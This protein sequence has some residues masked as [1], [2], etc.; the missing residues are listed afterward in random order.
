M[1]RMDESGGAAADTR[2]SPRALRTAA[3]LRDAARE[4][5]GELGWQAARVEDIVSRAGVSHGTFYHY[6]EN[7]AAVLEDLVRH[8]QADFVALAEAPWESDDV[9]AELARVIGGLLD[10]YERD[11]PVLQAWLHAAREER[12]FS[13]LYGKLRSLYVRR[14]AENLEPVLAASGRKDLPPARTLASAL[15][16]MVEH[17]AYAW[18]VLGED[19]ERDEAIAALVLIW[20]GALN[21]AAGFPVVDLT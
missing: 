17:F 10:V 6:Y 8:S 3:K 15:V 19:H 12:S 9:R 21:A 5:F 14:V 18:H 20:G 11:A 2:P 1:P 16:A 13:D 4:V 7:K